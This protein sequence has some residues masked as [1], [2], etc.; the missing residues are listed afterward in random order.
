MFGVSYITSGFTISD[1]SCILLWTFNASSWNLFGML[2]FDKQ[3]GTPSSHDL[4]NYES[5]GIS[6]KLLTSNWFLIALICPFP[7]R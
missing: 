1:K 3:K 4:F 6:I 2:P 7:Y 5:N